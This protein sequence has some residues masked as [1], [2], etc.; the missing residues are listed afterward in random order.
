M[1]EKPET[2][3]GVY[4][5]LCVLQSYVYCIYRE[6]RL[7]DSALPS[8]EATGVALDGDLCKSQLN[9]N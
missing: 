3:V 1:N 4:S 6:L 5:N 7:F 8:P 9:A 2:S